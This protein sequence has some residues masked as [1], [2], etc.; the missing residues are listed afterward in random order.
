MQMCLGFLILT[1]GD[2]GYIMPDIDLS[3]TVKTLFY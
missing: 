1:S 3:E 2:K